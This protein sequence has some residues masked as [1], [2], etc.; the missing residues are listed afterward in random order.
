MSSLMICLRGSEY[1]CIGGNLR[2]IEGVKII[3]NGENLKLEKY[4][5]KYDINRNDIVFLYTGR[6]VKEKGVK[7]LILAFNKLLNYSNNKN[8]KLLIV[9]K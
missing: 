8:L 3:K 2:L 1:R 6:L 5:E 9:R 7:E 4:R